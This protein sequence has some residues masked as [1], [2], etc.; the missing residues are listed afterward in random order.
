MRMDWSETQLIGEMEIPT[1]GGT[2]VP[3]PSGSGTMLWQRADHL[4]VAADLRTGMHGRPLMVS[5]GHP[6]RYPTPD[7]IDDIVKSFFSEGTETRFDG[8]R[9][10]EGGETFPFY[11]A[12]VSEVPKGESP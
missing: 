4:T 7:E 2:L 11:I 6:F 1:K 5:I 12:S 9:Y 8:T 3:I 10:I